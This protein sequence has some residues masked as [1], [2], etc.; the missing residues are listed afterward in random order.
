MRNYIKKV[1]INSLSGKFIQSPELLSDLNIISGANGSGKTDFLRFIQRNIS[2]SAIIE[3][4]NAERLALA[5]FNPKRN[6]Q[7]VLAESAY[8]LIRQDANAEQN[9]LNVFLNQQIQDDSFQTIKSI[10]EYLILSAEKLVD[11][12]GKTRD[13]STQIIQRE[14]QGIL[15]RIFDYQIDLSW[16][17]VDRRYDSGIVKSGDAL[18][19]NQ[20]SSGENAL[21]SLIFAI[22]YSKESIDVYLVDEPE[23]HL[24]WQLEEKLFE[25]LD[26][27]AK[28]HRKQLIVVTH[29][30]A[31]FIKPFSEYTQFFMWADGQITIKQKPDTNLLASLSGDIVKIIDGIT[32]EERL[33]FVEDKRQKEVLEKIS[34]IISKSIE[35]T[36]LGNCEKVKL[37]AKAFKKMRVDNVFFLIDGD[38]KPLTSTELAECHS[39]LVQLKKYCIE[40]YFLDRDILSS[41]DRSAP[42]K[43][44]ASELYASVK[45][46]NAQNFS[47][48]KIL[49][50]NKEALTQ[51]VLDRLDA[52]AFLKNLSGLLGFVDEQVFIF[53]YID[54]VKRL[55]RLEELFSEVISRIFI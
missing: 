14:Y 20:L 19:F 27:F 50:P 31:C 23:I 11:K 12:D 36:Q 51:E 18:K 45:S 47:A 10:S 29:S 25:F 44:I 49:L 2:N 13:E 54:E 38:N 21:I 53:T 32:V 9:A 8:Q 46:V 35:I 17:V 22:Y 26:W 7:K 40:N 3:V 43:D 52:D 34:K 42:K 30:R 24:N 1:N 48:V 37:Q 5:S 33:V 4:Y 41:I 16:S 15:Q 28:E 6:A 39:S 55:G